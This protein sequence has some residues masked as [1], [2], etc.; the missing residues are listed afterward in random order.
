MGLCMLAE[1]LVIEDLVDELVPNS[2]ILEFYGKF[3]TE[4]NSW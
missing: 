4:E 2:R 3:A 1:K